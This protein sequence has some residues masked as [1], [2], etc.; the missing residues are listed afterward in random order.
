[1]R[2]AIDHYHADKGQYPNSLGVLVTQ[3]YITQI[4]TDPFTSRTDSWRAVH[5]KPSDSR[6]GVAIGVYDVRSGSEAI[7][8]DGTRG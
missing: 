7:A 5:E 1:M 3:R 4:P 2:Q 6:Q 8:M